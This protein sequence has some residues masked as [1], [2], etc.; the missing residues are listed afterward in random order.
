MKIFLTIWIIAMLTGRE[1]IAGN[2]GL[3]LG[4]PVYGA[5]YFGVAFSFAL[6]VSAGGF[7]GILLDAMYRRIFPI[8]SIS[9]TLITLLVIHMTRNGHRQMP[10][11]P[12]GAGALCGAL[13]YVANILP[14]LLWNAPFP[15]PDVFSMGVFQISGGCIFMLVQVWIF[16]AVNFRCDLPKFIILDSKHKISGER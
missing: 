1:L 12:L 6:G 2:I 15:G 4:L 10:L 11:S 16:D 3:P 8:A 14:G 7:A 5:V 13:L 9:Y